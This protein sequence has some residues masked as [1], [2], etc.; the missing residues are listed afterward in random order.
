MDRKLL[1][2]L[3]LFFGFLLFASQSSR[4]ASRS[5]LA[6]KEIM[7]RSRYSHDFGVIRPNEIK[8]HLFSFPNP[9]AT[10]VRPSGVSASCGC[11]RA[12][13][14]KK[15]YA[16]LEDITVNVQLKSNDRASEMR[17]NL[18]IAFEDNLIPDYVVEVRAQVRPNLF[19]DSDRLSFGEYAG[20]IFATKSV[21]IRNFSDEDWSGVDVTCDVQWISAEC[22]EMP[23]EEG[24]PAGGRQAWLCDLDL[25]VL[26]MPPGIHEGSLFIRDSSGA[27]ELRVPIELNLRPN[28]MA[29]PGSWYF[30]SGDSMAQASKLVLRPDI[31]AEISQLNFE[32]SDSVKEFL[33]MH[34]DPLDESRT[35]YEL[36]ARCKVRPSVET[37]GEIEVYCTESP[38]IHRI[39]IPVLIVP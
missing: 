20:N 21:T 2:G 15:W 16:P 34:L 31:A 24:D 36:K 6:R 30:F 22:Q 25:S 8:Q 27:N 17:H 13:V 1:I 29:F 3:L 5:V 11:V 18:T 14:E 10:A 12:L 7:S 32:A 23:V 4:K 33:E 35:R 9:A 37:H 26:E 28:I 19:V 39:L 38:K